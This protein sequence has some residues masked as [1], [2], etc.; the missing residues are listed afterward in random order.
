MI[1]YLKYWGPVILWSAWIF[2]ASSDSLSKSNTSLFF[3]PLLLWIYPQASPELLE[4]AHLALR[5]VGHFS[6]YFVLSFL[7]MRALRGQQGMAWVWRQ[8]FWTLAL[9][10]IYAWSDELHQSLVP[11]RSFVV[12]DVL[13]DF[14]GGTCAILMLYL[15]AKFRAPVP[16]IKQGRPDLGR[17][18]R[19][20]R[21]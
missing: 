3:E 14:A 18:A 20:R 1:G 17:P 4:I 8:G 21:G 16:G 15:R 5:K 11:S 2:Y 7:L 6:E 13:L 12:I 19:R 10:W 9:V